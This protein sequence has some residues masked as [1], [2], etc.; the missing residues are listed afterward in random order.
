MSKYGKVINK[1][2]IKLLI[3]AKKCQKQLKKCN[4]YNNYGEK[5]IF[6]KDINNIKKIF[7]IDQELD[8]RNLTVNKVFFASIDAQRK[9]MIQEKQVEDR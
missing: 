3:C 4:I 9:F 5:L 2:L 1:M 8:R 7:E 6:V